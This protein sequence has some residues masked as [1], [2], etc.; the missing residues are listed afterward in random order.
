MKLTPPPPSLHELADQH[1]H[2]AQSLGYGNF[3]TLM[4]AYT[5]SNARVFFV[6]K[7]AQQLP[8][9]DVKKIISEQEQ[10]S[11]QAITVVFDGYITDT[12]PH[13]LPGSMK[14]S[15]DEGNPRVFEAIT[16]MIITP[17]A[18]ETACDFYRYI[19][20]EDWE[21]TRREIMVQEL[22]EN[23]LQNP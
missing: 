21:W 12:E 13:L 19:P 17:A 4:V 8:L 10:E 7:H 2:M 11:L 9:A 14:S 16:T 3:Q 23:P 22:Q 15:F 20:S 6:P 1:R 5:D 18:I